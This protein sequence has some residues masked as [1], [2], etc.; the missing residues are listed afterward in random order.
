MKTKERAIIAHTTQCPGYRR[1][2]LSH[3]ISIALAF[4]PRAAPN[5]HSDLK[6]KQCHT[7]T[8]FLRAASSVFTHFRVLFFAFSL[9][10]FTTAFV[11]NV[12]LLCSC[13][14]TPYF[15]GTNQSS[16][17]GSGVTG[18]AKTRLA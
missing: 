9:R 3:S 15:K 14:K 8:T 18:Q 6:T 17:V 16:F 4:F 2:L 10:H 1:L 5:R 7:H 13:N 12:I 11:E